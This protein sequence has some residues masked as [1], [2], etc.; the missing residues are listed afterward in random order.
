VG[1][2]IW[3]VI[4]DGGYFIANGEHF[5]PNPC[6]MSILMKETTLPRKKLLDAK[7]LNSSQIK[8]KNKEPHEYYRILW[9]SR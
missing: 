1:P 7:H 9:Q 6:F 5:A 3:H 4:H 8:R 2:H